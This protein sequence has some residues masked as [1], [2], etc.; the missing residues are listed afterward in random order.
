MRMPIQETFWAERFGVVIDESG[1]PWMAN[2]GEPGYWRLLNIEERASRRRRARSAPI[3]HSSN[4]KSRVS[5]RG[6]SRRNRDVRSWSADPPIADIAGRFGKNAQAIIRGRLRRQR[7]GRAFQHCQGRHCRPI[8]RCG[9][10]RRTTR[11]S[12]QADGLPAVGPTIA[13]RGYGARGIVAQ[14]QVERRPAL[15]KPRSIV[16]SLSTSGSGPK[17][18]RNGAR[19]PRRAKPALSRPRRIAFPQRGYKPR[20]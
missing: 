14:P 13:R 1:T 11:T 19:R 12:P 18:S 5:A 10:D 4:P 7:R 3:L 17:T 8:G 9:Q 15:V 2:C 16:V 6:H 20:H